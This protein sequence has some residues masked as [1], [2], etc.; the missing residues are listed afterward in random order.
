MYGLIGKVLKHSYSREIHEYLGNLEYK[1]YELC[2]EDFLKMVSE[3][4]YMGL[5]ITMPYKIKAMEFMDYV[6]EEAKNIGSINTIVNKNGKLYGYNTDY[7]GFEFIINYFDTQ[8]EGK[9]VLVLGNG[10][11][12]KPVFYYLEKNNIEYY[13]VKSKP[14]K[15]VITYE[16]A[17]N[18]HS[19]ADV[20]INA[21]PVGMY[22]NVSFSPISLEGY[23]KVSLVIDMIAN[24]VETKLMRLAKEKNILAIGGLE[25]LVAQAK[26][27]EELFTDIAIEDSEIMDIVKKIEQIMK[28]KP[29]QWKN[30]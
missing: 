9:K 25:L 19:D 22:P 29:G 13:I 20:I 21:S 1:L 10:G 15:G 16:Q 2:E 14:D 18:Q 7:Y 11:A 8:L 28:N 5:N 26:R 27:S 30:I 17:R 6:S 24:P 4:K 3:K 12:A 23:D